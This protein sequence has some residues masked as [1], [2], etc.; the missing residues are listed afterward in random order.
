MATWWLLAWAV[1]HAL[2]SLAGAQGARRHALRHGLLDQPGARRSHAVPTPRGGGIGIAI[3]WL[4]ACACLAVL[5]G[6]DAW[7]A[8]ALGAA[9]LCVAGIGWRDDRRPLPVWSRLVAQSAGAAF[10]GL[11]LWTASHSLPVSLAAA[12]TVMVL[13]N[14][15]N[16][17]DGIDGLAATQGVIA[18]LALGAWGGTP[19]SLLLGIALAA[20]CLGFLPLNLPRARLFLGDVGSGAIGLGIAVLLVMAATRRSADGG[21]LGA[22]AVV[23]LPVAVFLVD[24]TLTLARRIVRGERWWTPHVEHAYQKLAARRR[25]HVPVTVAYGVASTAAVALGVAV[26]S[27]AV[28]LQLVVVAGLLLAFFAGWCWV[29]WERTAG[30]TAQG[31]R[32]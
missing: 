22:A 21:S 13:V 20:A 14:V 26:S 27:Q 29:Q 6:V 9:M 28:P 2:V 4:L 12:A 5:P 18:G 31:P 16:F 32:K 3:S 11:G 23:L 10:V 8:A 1:V 30:L 25:L 15:W 7:L 17:M 19:V 24:A